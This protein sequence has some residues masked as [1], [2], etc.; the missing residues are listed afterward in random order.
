MVEGGGGSIVVTASIDAYNGAS[1][2]ASYAIR[3]A[4]EL[5]LMRHS[6]RRYGVV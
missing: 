3:K 4:A 5:A 2:R 6:T 1:T